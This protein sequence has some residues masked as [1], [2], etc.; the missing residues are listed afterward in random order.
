MILYRLNDQIL[1]LDGLQDL[2]S[3]QYLNAA[4]LTGAL[5]DQF[6]NPIFTGVS[7]AYVPNSDGVYQAVVPGAGF[8]PG[9]GAGYKLI[10]DGNQ[11]GSDHIHLVI[12][13]EIQDRSQ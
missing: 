1:E 3:L 8:N 11:S 12:Q 9:L 6:S 4:T 2:L 10:L 5:Y 7:F 13:V